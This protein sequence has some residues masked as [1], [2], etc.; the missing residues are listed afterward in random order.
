MAKPSVMNRIR[1]GLL[2]SIF[3]LLFSAVDVHASDTLLVN[4]IQDFEPDGKGTHSGWQ[5][6]AWQEIP[7]ID[8]IATPYTA[9]FKILYSTK[10]IYLL[11]QGS[12]NKVTSK[13]KKDF[14]NMFNGD[15]FEAFFQPDI[16]LPLYFEYE[17]NPYNK[18]LPIL[19]PHL[20]GGVMGWAPWH[21]TKDRK[22]KKSISIRREKGKMVAWTAEVFIPF[23]L[24]SPLIS[25]QPKPGVVWYANFC[26]LDYDSG[27]MI[28]WAWSPIAVSFHEYKKYKPIKFN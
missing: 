28:K 14:S 7:Q 24:L 1:V 21:Y 9:Q 11:F 4:R 5:Q 2:V 25:I 8:T 26:R 23:K 18:E 6:T 15:V 17:I 27:K 13:Y 20:K 19:I 3:L 10:G 12:D 22:T 16:N